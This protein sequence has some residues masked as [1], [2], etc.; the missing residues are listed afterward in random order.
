MWKD[1]FD[2]Y[3]HRSRLQSH[4]VQLRISGQPGFCGTLMLGPSCCSGDLVE[5][6]NQRLRLLFAFRLVRTQTSSS[7]D[8]IRAVYPPQ[9]EQPQKI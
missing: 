3:L 9:Q 8:L 7:A 4:G 5:Q 1:S 6:A 2:S